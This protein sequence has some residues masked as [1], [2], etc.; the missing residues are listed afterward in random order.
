M[1]RPRPLVVTAFFICT[2]PFDAV[3]REGSEAM[4]VLAFDQLISAAATRGVPMGRVCGA[5]C[6][7]H[8]WQNGGGRS[9]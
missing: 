2:G 3:V 1:R 7:V 5:R 9:C 4:D 6:V 8:T